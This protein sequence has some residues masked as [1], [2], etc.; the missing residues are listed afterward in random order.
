MA[1]LGGRGERD[2]CSDGEESGEPIRG[3]D[4]GEGTEVFVS[5]GGTERSSVRRGEIAAGES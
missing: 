1:G 4:G 5:A 2:G 3:D